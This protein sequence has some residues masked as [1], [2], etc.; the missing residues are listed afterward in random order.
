MS[1]DASTIPQYNV[2]YDQYQLISNSS[3]SEKR[4]SFKCGTFGAASLHK[5][6]LATGDFGGW[7]S[8][9]DLER[10][11]A[12]VYSARAHDVIVNCIDGVGGLGVGGGA[13]ELV[14]GSRDGECRPLVI[15]TIMHLE[16]R[17]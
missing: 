17:P 13:P 4:H 15:T 16:M 2:N 1:E 11:E 12:P 9:W 6:R 7:L 10:I 3:Q 8:V 14:T 5:R